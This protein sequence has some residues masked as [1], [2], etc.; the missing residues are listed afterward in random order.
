MHRYKK[1]KKL[2]DGSFGIALLVK[3][4]EDDRYYA[5]KVIKIDSMDKKQM[6]DAINEVNLL[7]AMKHPNIISY[8]ESF[9]EKSYLWIVMDYA[10]DG[11]LYKKI[12]VQKELGKYISENQILDWFVQMAFA[13]KH[14]HDHRIL[15]RDL[16]TQNIFMNKN[17]QIKLGDFGIARVLQHT[18]DWAKT[19][20]GTPYYLSPEIW[21]NMPYNQKSDVWS[22]GCIL[23]EM[24]TLKH[25]F[26]ATN[27]KGLVLKILRN[28]YPE[29]PKQ[30]SKDLKDLI[31]SMLIKDPV[32]RPSINKVLEMDFLRVP[33]SKMYLDV[34]EKEAIEVDQL[35]RRVSIK[36]PTPDL[37]EESHSRKVLFDKSNLS[38]EP[39]RQKAVNTHSTVNKRSKKP[40][41]ITQVNEEEKVDKGKENYAKSGDFYEEEEDKDSSFPSKFAPIQTFLQ[42]LP[43][44]WP[45]DSQSYRIE[46]LRVYLEEKLGDTTFINAYN[47]Y[48]NSSELDEKNTEDIDS[49]LGSKKKYVGL[50]YQLIVCE[51]SLRFYKG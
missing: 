13:T 15:H 27:I 35:A 5:M 46:A 33:L 6:K 14:I 19:A 40:L 44:V 12:E 47:Y 24:V 28:N 23:Y 32:K 25:A 4:R 22:L 17:G 30:Y 16:K 31:S 18:S 51:D 7:K 26:D 43:G 41:K 1:I 49:I 10:D 37:V 36:A 42:N 39:K 2:G 21:Q 45:T 9:I 48:L 20:I 50:I 11:D 3:S 8:K 34:T 38:K 29:I